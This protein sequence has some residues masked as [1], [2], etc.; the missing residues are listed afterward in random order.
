MEKQV[1]TESLAM[2]FQK[3]LRSK[4]V[5]SLVAL[6]CLAAAAG[7]GYRAGKSKGYSHAALG[8]RYVP[9]IETLLPEQ[10]FSEVRNTRGT[11]QA[12]ASEMLTEV[13]VQ[14][15]I[16]GTRDQL[17]TWPAQPKGHPDAAR[18]IAQLGRGVAEFKGT[19]QEH[20]FTVEL[21]WRLKHEE[22]YDRWL[23]VYLK[24]LY[25]HPT[26]PF[27]TRLLKDAAP[28]SLAVG[29]WDELT[30]AV[31]FMEQIPTE[32]W[33][34]EVLYSTNTIATPEE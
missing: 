5:V 8:F 14:F 12:L 32:Y 23:D 20:R 17:R 18:A 33:P 4:L 6:A 13:Q 10:S 1:D 22:R 11:L 15:L 28:I 3:C 24:A 26:Q 34:P 7:A 19:E 21:L 16:P 25:Q 30:A 29:R 2:R 31:Y 9:S 27:V